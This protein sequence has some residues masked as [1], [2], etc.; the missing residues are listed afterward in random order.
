M[1]ATDACPN[2]LWYFAYGSNLND[3]VFR[4]RRGMRVLAVERG[5]L[6]G[7]AL[8]F[9]LPVGPGERGVA[10][11]VPAEDAHVWGALYLLAVDD[12]DRLDRTEGVHMGAYQRS[13][14]QVA[15]DD[16][17]TCDAFT[18]RSPVGKTGRKPSA[19]YIGL[20]VA[21]ARQRGLPDDWVRWL[22]SLELA[23][24]A[25]EAAAS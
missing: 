13:I 24:D 15:R 8:R 3:A 21:G 4:D 7:F 22:E 2:P 18:Y 17:S 20:I 12:C 5:R 11:V 25:R 23:V 6:D 1:T 9:D 10:N 16:R 14:V 19:R